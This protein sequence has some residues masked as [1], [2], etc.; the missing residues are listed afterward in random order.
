MQTQN[1]SRSE[2]LRTAAILGRF[3]KMDAREVGRPHNR[4]S[5]AN[6]G[7][8][9]TGSALHAAVPADL[10]STGAFWAPF[11]SSPA[12]PR[13]AGSSEL[14]ASLTEELPHDIERLELPYS[15]PA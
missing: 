6:V 8:P 2:Q 12:A 15:L 14:P 10:S 1:Y 3:R 9:A 5:R 7:A 11:A 4:L 13:R